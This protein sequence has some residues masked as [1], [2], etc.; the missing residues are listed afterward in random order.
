MVG[1]VERI[2]R[3]RGIEHPVQMSLGITDGRSVYAFR[4]STEGR[5]RTLYHSASIAAVAEI[6]P[7]VRRFS[8]D[9]RAVVSEP[10]SDLAEAWI[11]VPESSFVEVRGGEVRIEPFEPIA[12]AD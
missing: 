10:L 3:D 4:Y 7:Q 8:P 12:P 6:A 2:G 5:S 1:L 9:A 11:E